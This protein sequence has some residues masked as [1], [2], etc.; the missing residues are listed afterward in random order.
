M[1]FL[2]F[3]KVDMKLKARREKR[4]QK[5]KERKSPTAMP[6]CTRT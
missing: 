2:I 4:E 3:E 5:R 6:P 1:I